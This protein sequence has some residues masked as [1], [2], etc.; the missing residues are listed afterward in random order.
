MCPQLRPSLPLARE[1]RKL[2]NF[3][4][5]SLLYSVTCCSAV[6]A[7]CGLASLSGMPSPMGWC[8]PRPPMPAQLMVTL[9]HPQDHSPRSL[10][11]VL[12]CEESRGVLSP[13]TTLA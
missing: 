5:L 1:P 11:T 10:F 2:R 4:A 8:P 12:V 6:V 9:S 3:S 13:A 7:G